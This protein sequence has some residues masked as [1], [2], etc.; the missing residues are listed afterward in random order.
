M[1]PN[2]TCCTS[3]ALV[4]SLM[5]GQ[6]RFPTKNYARCLCA[7]ASL[8]GSSPDQFTLE[9][10]ETAQNSQ[11][12]ATM[13]RRG[14]SPGVSKRFE[15]CPFFPDRPQQVQEIACGPRQ[16]IEPGDDQYVALR[17]QGHQLS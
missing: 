14:V 17:E 3:P 4:P 1:I 15:A 16:P 2:G 11:H 10:G 12:Q 6:L 5:A 13:R 8:A 9:F 7:L